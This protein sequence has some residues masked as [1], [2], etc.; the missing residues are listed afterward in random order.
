MRY[1]PDFSSGVIVQVPEDKNSYINVRGIGASG[2]GDIE[3]TGTITDI[4]SDGVI[5]IGNISD[6][7]GGTLFQYRDLLK[8]DT[9]IQLFSYRFAS[10]SGTA[11]I[12]VSGTTAVGV[13]FSGSTGTN[14]NLSQLTYYVFGIDPQTGRMPNAVS[15]TQIGTKV[16]NPDLWNID[17]YVDLNFSRTSQYALPVIYRVWG[18]RVDFLGVIGN[19]KIGYPGSSS[20]FRDLGSTEIPNWETNPRLPSFLEG[21]FSIGGSEITQVRTIV[22]KGNVS[23]LPNQLGSA[24]NYIQCSGL[25]DVQNYS[26]NDTVRFVV[27]DTKYIQTAVSLAASGDIKEVF[28]PAGTYNIR[29]TFFVNSFSSD[30]SNLSLRG[31]GESS[32]IRRLPCTL[33]N[34]TAPGLINFSGASQSPRLAG[35]RLRSLRFDGNRDES[36]SLVSPVESEITV[37][38]RYGD[39]IVIE[40]C[41][42]TDNGGGG[43]SVLNSNSVTINNCSIRRTGRSYEQNVSPLLIDTCEN[44][45][46]QG[47][48][49]ELA[50]TGPRI[51]STEFSTVN[52]NIIRGCGDRGIDLQT[53]SQWNVQGNVAYSDNDSII[54]SI[55]T[56]NNEYS[57]ATIEVRK[58]F[59]LDP[60][61]MTVTFGGESVGIA[62]GSIDAAIYTLNSNGLKESL[63]GYFRVLETS[64]QLVAGIFSLTLPG[65]NT[66]T[67]GSKSIPSTLSLTNVP[68]Y[69]YEVK[70]SVLIGKIRPLSIRSQVIGSTNYVAIQ[71]R[72]SSDLLGFQIYS[73]TNTVENDKIQIKGF[74]NTNLAGWDQNASYTVVGTDSDTNSILLGTIGGLT[75]SPTPIEF[76][77]GTLSILRSNYFIADG[78]IFVHTGE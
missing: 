23:I 10:V 4:D 33:S 26:L 58:G 57:R 52:G 12:S 20:V 2:K 16:L 51:I 24:P 5:T 61:Y 74:S 7:A 48:I 8:G 28:F 50:T 15:I 21:V 41:G 60:V 45:V 78:N 17:Q 65:I 55:D 38:V 30:Y 75:L 35:L 19:N 27:D 14:P 73:A 62:K 63:V 37:R 59:A 6:G 49:L 53:S 3:F 22:G 44:V 67:V 18:S 42:F 29:D 9:E 34:Q 1:I 25:S 76:V 64:D 36:F 43:L 32:L 39:G 72:N 68:G 46:A 31:V 66:Q 13:D 56:Y 54:R 71:F 69:M 70:G 47:N 40:D 77:G 11:S